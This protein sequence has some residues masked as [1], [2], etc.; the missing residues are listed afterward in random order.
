MKANSKTVAPVGDTFYKK[1]YKCRKLKG[2][3][4]AFDNMRSEYYGF[5]ALCKE[6]DAQRGHA[7]RLKCQEKVCKCHMLL[8]HTLCAV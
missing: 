8:L 7:R 6:Y 1:C 4:E 3:A 2:C 5:S